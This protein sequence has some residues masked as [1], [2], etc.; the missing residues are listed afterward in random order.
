MEKSAN[1][2]AIAS[3]GIYRLSKPIYIAIAQW[4]K[5]EASGS[6][7]FPE[8]AILGKEREALG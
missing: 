1:L 6:I 4:S 3:P 7:S 2:A 8:P 5:L